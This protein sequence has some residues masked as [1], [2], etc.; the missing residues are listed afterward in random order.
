VSLSCLMNRQILAL[1]SFLS[2]IN[3]DRDKGLGG[4]P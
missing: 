3:A 1:S 4:D 2:D